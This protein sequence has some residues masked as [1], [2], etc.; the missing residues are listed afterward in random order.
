M[1]LTARRILAVANLENVRVAAAR[2]EREGVEV[3]ELTTE[4]NLLVFVQMLV[5]KEDDL[6]FEQRRP[7]QGGE[8]RG[9]GA[10]QINALQ[11]GTK[12]D[13]EVLESDAHRRGPGRQL[14]AD[15]LVAHCLV[16]V[17]Y[18]EAGAIVRREQ[19]FGGGRV[20][21]QAGSHCPSR[22]TRRGSRSDP[23]CRCTDPDRAQTA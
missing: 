9:L 5:P 17:D 21:S 8:F 12:R 18:P 1:F 4:R 20:A 23:Q 3:P 19:L 16:F 10:F 7:D 13:A 11:D 14:L 2:T 15:R 22:V 6:A